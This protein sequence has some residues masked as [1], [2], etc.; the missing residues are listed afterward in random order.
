MDSVKNIAWGSSFGQPT[1]FSPF[2]V[3]LPRTAIHPNTE[4]TEK[5]PH[6]FSHSIKFNA[7]LKNGHF[8]GIKDI[9]GKKEGEKTS[10]LHIFTQRYISEAKWRRGSDKRY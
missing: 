5:Y 2:D 1:E 9:Y 7:M 10:W 3:L 4:R 6:A 8:P